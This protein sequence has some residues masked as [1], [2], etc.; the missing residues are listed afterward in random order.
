[1]ASLM[2]FSFWSVTVEVL[3]SSFVT[4]AASNDSDVSKKTIDVMVWCCIKTLQ[5]W[6]GLLVFLIVFE[7]FLVFSK[8]LFDV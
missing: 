8:L 1:M 4:S 6:L 3:W 2:L 5:G 7:F